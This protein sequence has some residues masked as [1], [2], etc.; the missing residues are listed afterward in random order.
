M[1]CK[2]Y[3]LSKNELAIRN[4]HNYNLNMLQKRET[5]FAKFTTL[6]NKHTEKKKKRRKICINGKHLEHF[7]SQTRQSIHRT[8]PPGSY[9]YLYISNQ[10]SCS[11]KASG[12]CVSAQNDHHPIILRANPSP[13]VAGIIK[14]FCI[15]RICI[16]RKDRGWVSFGH[17][18]R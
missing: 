11:R 17:T 12:W 13:S 8:K 9:S 5:V 16:I 14:I 3:I 2:S 1:L 10:R 18:N 7:S 4:M 6:H 15:L